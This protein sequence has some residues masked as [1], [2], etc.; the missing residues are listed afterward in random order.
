MYHM[1]INITILH[2]WYDGVMDCSLCVSCKEQ[3]LCGCK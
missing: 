1:M 2:H 3:Q